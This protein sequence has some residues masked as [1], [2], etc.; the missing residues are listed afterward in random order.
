MK[1][2]AV[3]TESLESFLME[4]QSVDGGRSVR[5]Y[6]ALSTFLERGPSPD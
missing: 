6:I 5:S 3:D 4:I 1:V 2:R